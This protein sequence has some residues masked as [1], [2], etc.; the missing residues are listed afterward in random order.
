SSISSGIITDYLWYFGDGD[1]SSFEHPSHIYLNQGLLDVNLIAIS[2]STCIGE[3]TKEQL[4]EVFSSLHENHEQFVTIYPNPVSDK[5]FID[6]GKIT[7]CQ[8]ISIF[9]TVGMKVLSDNNAKLPCTIDVIGLKQGI[10][11]LQLDLNE[12]QLS[13]RILIE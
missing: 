10:Y 8:S 5:L 11:F 1:S 2:D 13:R 7:N 3:L 12:F 4:I 9:N 6:V